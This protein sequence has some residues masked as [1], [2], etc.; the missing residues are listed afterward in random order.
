MHADSLAIFTCTG[1]SPITVDPKTAFAR[2]LL[3][4]TLL[5][6]SASAGCGGNA[7]PSASGDA[8]AD[9]AAPSLDD[10]IAALGSA[11]LLVFSVGDLDGDGTFEL[12]LSATDTAPSVLST[13]ADAG[14]AAGP[15]SARSLAL[16]AAPLPVVLTHD[17]NGNLQ[18]AASTSGFNIAKAA[19]IAAF[20]T[21]AIGVAAPWARASA[22]SRRLH[23][24]SR[25]SGRHYSMGTLNAL[26]IA[27]DALI[28]ADSS[29][30]VPVSPSRHACPVPP[31]VG[32][33]S[34]VA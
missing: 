22:L 8:S 17:Q 12:V 20:P 31:Q 9:V 33:T 34:L 27:N 21:A 19:V 25:A 7:N 16:T 11:K 6:I 15:V 10:R 1:Y 24:C 29:E 2:R 4:A 5:A 32:R 18:V 14:S 13:Q 3:L 30:P 23:A 26:T 28:A